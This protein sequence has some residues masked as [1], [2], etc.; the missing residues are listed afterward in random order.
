MC[1]YRLLVYGHVMICPPVSEN[2][3]DGGSV[4]FPYLSFIHLPFTPNTDLAK[5]TNFAICRIRHLCCPMGSLKANEA[6]RM[7][8]MQELMV[9]EVALLQQPIKFQQF[10]NNFVPTLL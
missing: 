5:F 10:K 6:Q 4:I 8:G 2:C 1:S 7:M 3:F 9:K